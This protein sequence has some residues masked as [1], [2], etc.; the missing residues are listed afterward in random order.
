MIKKIKVCLVT[1]FIFILS[2]AMTA[3]TSSA[4]SELS[5]Y[6]FEIKARKARP[7]EPL[8]QFSPLPKFAYPLLDNRRSPFKPREVKVA[9]DKMAPNTNRPKQPLENF[10]LDSLKFVGILKQGSTIWALISEPNGEIARVKPGDYMGQNFGKVI[11]INE[12]LLRLEETV[13]IAGKW[14]KHITTINLNA[15]E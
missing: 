8:P 5:R 10:P 12:K 1:L 7:I 4:D 3:C 9:Q 13:Q 14:K 6:I 15:R 11:G 2:V